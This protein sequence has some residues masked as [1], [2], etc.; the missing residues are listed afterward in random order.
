MCKHFDVV[1]S[2]I[3][4]STKFS[5]QLINKL[6]TRCQYI[7]FKVMFRNS[8]VVKIYIIRSKPGPVAKNAIPRPSG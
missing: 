7:K 4:P 3:I 6:Y 8:S 5:A 2:P 1:D